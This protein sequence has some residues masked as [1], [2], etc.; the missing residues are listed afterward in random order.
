MSRIESRLI[1]LSEDSDDDVVFVREAIR[2]AGIVN[3]TYR[4]R[5]GE[6]VI[7]YLS[8]QG[9]YAD[10]EIHPLPFLI[11]LDLKLPR[12]NGFEALAWIRQQR[13]L[14][15]IVVIMLSG[16]FLPE[17][18]VHAYDLGANSFLAKPTEL[19]HLIELMDDVRKYW[20]S[21]NRHALYESCL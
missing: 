1:L 13:M 8:G 20:L 17:E 14:K 18:L 2:K 11:L 4:V 6:A 19:N 3:P 12:T 15:R 21:G 7:R 5:T 16:S 9:V 10:R